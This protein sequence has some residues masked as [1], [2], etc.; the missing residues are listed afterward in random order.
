MS[1][2]APIPLYYRL[3]TVLRQKIDGGEI[4]PGARFPT[5]A[6]L[7]A[8]YGMARVT[9][10]QALA[11]LARDGLLVR[12]RGAGTVVAPPP[13][14]RGS[15]KLTGF[16]E[17][18]IAMGIKTRVR[19]LDFR[20]VPAT[21]AVALA[22]EVAEGAP[23]WLVR[24]LRLAGGQPFSHIVAYLPHAVGG[25]LRRR[26]LASTPLLRLLET[27][28]GLRLG[29]ATQ[30]IEAT[31]ADGYLADVLDVPVGAP[32]LSIERVVTTTSHRPVEYVRTHYRGD[33][34]KYSVTLRR[35]RPGSGSWTYR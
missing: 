20:S 4:P 23:V 19:V 17:D 15:L 31:A 1:N 8:E 6:A 21:P 7:Q 3:E 2:P 26:D 35:G 18:L 29:S 10:R 16:I 27:R 9:V 24:R 5:E 22:L 25:P 13:T 11:A 33:R 14:P 12:R 34:Y 30:A 28:C 32:L